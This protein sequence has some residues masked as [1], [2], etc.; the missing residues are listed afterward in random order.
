MNEEDLYEYISKLWAML[1]W[2]NKH[3]VVE[4]LV[5]FP[6]SKIF[7]SITSTKSIIVKLVLGLL[8]RLFRAG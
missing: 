8:P 4:K 6:M 2:G 5:N 3:Y 7:L 1:I